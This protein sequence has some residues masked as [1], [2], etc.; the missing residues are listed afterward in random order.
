MVEEVMEITDAAKDREMA[1]Q[2]Q[3]AEEKGKVAALEKQIEQ[4]QQGQAQLMV[5]LRVQAKVLG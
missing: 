5:A 3:V 1:L 2:K 4:L